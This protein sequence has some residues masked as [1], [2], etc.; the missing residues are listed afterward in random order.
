MM[1]DLSW[2]QSGACYGLY[3]EIGKIDLW[4]P[5][6]NPGG[7]KEGR[8]ITGEKERVR[9][10]LKY[11]S[12]CPVRETCLEYAVQHDCPGIWGGM[13]T[14]ERRAYAKQRNKLAG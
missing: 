6:E 3:Y 7:P 1:E 14:A 9:R 10:A 2:Q 8:G 12:Q 11:C 13:D 5:P 4:F